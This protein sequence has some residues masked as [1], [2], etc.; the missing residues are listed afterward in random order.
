MVANHVRL[1]VLIDVVERDVPLTVSVSV[2]EEDIGVGSL[3]LYEQHDG[4]AWIIR[5]REDRIRLAGTI[6]IVDD[7]FRVPFSASPAPDFPRLTLP[8]GRRRRPYCASAPQ[9]A[10]RCA[11]KQAADV[12]HA[13]GK[14]EAFALCLEAIHPD[15]TTLVA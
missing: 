2:D 1:A 4:L 11:R 10:I 15:E 7:A 3:A 9:T 12:I 14:I 13:D 6:E 8:L 5:D